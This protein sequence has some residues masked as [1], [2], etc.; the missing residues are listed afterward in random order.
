MKKITTEEFINRANEIHGNKYD[1]IN[2]IY[3]GTHNKVR[4]ICPI[5]G[6]FLQSPH[7]HLKGNGCK[8]CSDNN[9][10]KTLENFIKRSNEIHGNKYDYSKVEYVNTRTKVCIICPK[11][12]EFWQTPDCH[13][14][15]CGCSKCSKSKS[16]NKKTTKQFIEEA[17]R[18]HG[19]KYD[20]SKVEY[21][22]CKIK[23]CI[24]CPKHGE[25]WQTPHIHLK[26]G[27]CLECYNE[28]GR[29]KKR[30]HDNEWFINK[31][32]EIHGNKYD[33]SKVEYK[34]IF[35]K[36]C[37]I[38]PI[39]G[40]FWQTPA[41]HIWAKN[42]C[43]K[44]GG[45]AK[46]TKDEFVEKARRVHGDKYD[47]SK[48]EYTGNNKTKVCI[49]CPTHGEFWQKPNCHLNGN[50][51]PKCKSSHLERILRV[52]FEKENI[53]FE[54]QKTFSWLKL[55]QLQYLD[56]FLPKYNIAIECQGEQHFKKSGWGKGDNGEKVIKRDLNKKKL[57]EKHGIEILYYSK[58]GIEYPYKVFENEK[59]LL[60]EIKNH[61]K[62]CKANL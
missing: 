49:I 35:T 11:H 47:Y 16:R 19:D 51:C 45:T 4:I 62:N 1:Y 26:G 46:L 27:G 25:F 3:A 41:S 28:N 32:K 10:K 23:V 2:V 56:F 52:F 36:V 42:G 15:G 39:H 7:E 33:Y 14:R 31:A 5:H 54:E 8:K 57:C 44:C 29:G 13:L 21:K 37:I 55:K 18:V 22:G 9:R 24:I 6:E 43:N 48:V 34:T 53:E 58:L 12:G 30:Q 40:E 20:Y 60:L 59:E 38:C 17:R 61:S 50:G